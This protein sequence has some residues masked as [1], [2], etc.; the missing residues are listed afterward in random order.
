MLN[1]SVKQRNM[2]VDI[3]RGIAML[4][5]VSWH[6]MGGCTENY[7]NN[8]LTDMIWTLQMPLFILISGYVTKYS[9]S[10]DSLNSLIRFLKK[11]TLAYLLPWIVWTFAIRGLIFRQFNY[12]DIKY[13]DN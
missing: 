13:F 10:V 4:M 8:P 3:L 2:T 9:K 12:F 11:R 6:T 1:E 7:Q 5:V